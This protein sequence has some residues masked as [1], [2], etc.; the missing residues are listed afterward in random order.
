MSQDD[1]DQFTDQKYLKTEQYHNAANLNAR[2]ELHSRFRTNQED[3]KVWVFSRFLDNLPENARVLELGCGA[4]DLWSINAGRIPPGWEIVLSDFSPGMLENTQ[5]V[6][7]SYPI[8]FQYK[9]VD[10]QAI[11]FEDAVFDAVIANH[12]LYHVPDREKAIAEIHRVLK[13]GG[14]LFAAT[15]GQGHMGEMRNLVHSID[16]EAE[17][18]LGEDEFGLENGRAQLSPYFSTILILHYENS[19]QVTETDPMVAYILSSKRSA[20]IE[21]NPQ[22]AA[23]MIE[24]TIKAD[25]VFHIQIHIGMFVAV[26]AQ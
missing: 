15:N 6:L 5:T 8:E 7:R 11:D 2:I 20:L 13:P 21:E 9:V 1:R 10:A 4:G 19:L 24:E 3:F 17:L 23:Q 25:G 22:L 14:V 12:M 18:T 26:K 16:P